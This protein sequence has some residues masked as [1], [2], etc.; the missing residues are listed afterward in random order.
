[1]AHKHKELYTRRKIRNRYNLKKSSLNR[2]RLCVYRSN[3]NIYAQVIDDISG[4][5]LFAAS[6]LEKEFKKQKLFGGNLDAAKKIGEII[7]TKAKSA[8]IKEVVF[9]RGGYIFTG[10]IKAL[11]ESAREGGLKF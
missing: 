5:T 3:Q 4:K 2:L 7:A 10:K 1:M 9:D 8:G 6:T 11:A